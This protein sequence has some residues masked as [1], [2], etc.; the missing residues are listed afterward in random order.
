[1]ISKTCEHGDPPFFCLFG[2][3]RSLPF[4]VVSFKKNLYV[5]T[6]WVRTSLIFCFANEF[7]VRVE[8]IF[9]FHFGIF[10]DHRGPIRGD[11][12]GDLNFLTKYPVSHKFRLQISRKL[13]VIKV[14]ALIHMLLATIYL[15]IFVHWH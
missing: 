5:G 1:M 14:S 12:R 2:K 11:L 7:S 15:I 8:P 10:Y 3:S 6:F 9:K 4:C 13:N